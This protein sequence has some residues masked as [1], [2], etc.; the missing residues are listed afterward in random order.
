MAE[1]TATATKYFRGIGR[2]KSAIA[3]VHLTKGKGVCTINGQTVTPSED[4]TQPLTLTGKSDYDI[5]VIVRG[6]GMT[7]Q[8]EAIKLG[9]ARAL[10]AL[11]AELK[12]TL[13]KAGLVTRD[14]RV[15]ERKKPGLK[16]AR[17]A[18]QWSKR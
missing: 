7:G 16:R 3:Q 8:H 18:P 14:P 12:P 11:D 13:R 15:K 1:R 5:T 2:R 17:R 4:W 10:T 6:G 9:I